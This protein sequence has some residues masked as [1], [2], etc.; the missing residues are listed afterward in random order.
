MTIKER[1]QHIQ[2]II[3]EAEQTYKREP[4][5]V[6][7]LAVSK[8][9][10]LQVIEQAISAGL[11]HFAESYYQE[12]EKK[13]Q[14]LNH[15]GTNWHFIGPI[16]SNKTKGIAQHFSWVHSINR[17]SIAKRLN[18]Y[19]PLEM[20]ALNVCL[21]VNIQEEATKSGVTLEE[22]YELAQ[23]FSNFLNLNYEGWP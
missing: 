8:Q 14:K 3:K 19:R 2:Q 23:R 4:G 6:L 21:Q 7:L 22:A 13:I 10:K 1:I 15:L 17:L 20:P 5:S 18:Q 9:H 16:Q 11:T 12:A